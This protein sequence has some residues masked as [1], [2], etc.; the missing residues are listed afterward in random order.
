MD[1]RMP[2]VVLIRLRVEH[3]TQ[4]NKTR[5]Q[6]NILGFAIFMDVLVLWHIVLRRDN[7]MAAMA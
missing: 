2:R 1:V 5:Q 3:E 7:R 6:S 4:N